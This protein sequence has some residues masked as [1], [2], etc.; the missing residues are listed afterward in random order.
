MMT[1]KKHSDSFVTIRKLQNIS[2][3]PIHIFYG[4]SPVYPNSPNT[5]TDPFFCDPS[6]CQTLSK[7][8]GLIYDS[9]D[10]DI[11][12]AAGKQQHFSVSLG[13]FVFNPFPMIKCFSMPGCTISKKDM[14]P[15]YPRFC[16]PGTRYPIFSVC[17]S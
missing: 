1:K 10:P 12:Y 6:L 9:N 14:I 4:T 8:N 11:F 3:Y 2:F 13:R 5:D 7:D 16:H 15:H 17:S